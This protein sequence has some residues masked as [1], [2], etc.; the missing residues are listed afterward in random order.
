M[1]QTIRLG[2]V[3]GIRIGLNGGAFVIVLLLA[4][5]WRSGSCRDSIRGVGRLR[6]L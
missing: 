1:R 3:A 4:A 6:T 2:R 5:G